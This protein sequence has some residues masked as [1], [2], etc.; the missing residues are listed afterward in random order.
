[1]GRVLRRV[2]V[3]GDVPSPTP[4]AD[5]VLEARECRLQGQWISTHRI[6]THKHLVYGI[7]RQTCRV[8][9][10]GI[11]AGNGEDPLRHQLFKLVGDPAGIAPI[12]QALRK[13]LR[14]PQPQIDRL[15]QQRA[16]VR[17]AWS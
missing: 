3:D 11:A 4:S 14:Q 17:A 7:L 15:Q 5:A 13:P 8:V 6:P 2:E 9:A 12:P 10:V 1:M 16:A